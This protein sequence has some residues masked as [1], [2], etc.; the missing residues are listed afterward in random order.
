MPLRLEWFC[1]PSRRLSGLRVG[2]IMREIR[3]ALAPK[4]RTAG[5]ERIMNE[6]AGILYP[7]RRRQRSWSVALRCAFT[8][9]V[10]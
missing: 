4:V 5:C 6:G 7:R 9:L 1:P 3:L 8:A 2:G 10:C